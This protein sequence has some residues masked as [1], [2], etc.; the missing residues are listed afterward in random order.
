MNSA[1]KKVGDLRREGFE[2]VTRWVRRDDKTKLEH[3]NWT[4]YSGWP[5]AFVV[6][7]TV[8]YIGLTERILRSRMDDYRPIKGE[9]TSRMQQLITAELA[10][11]RDVFVFGRR[12]ADVAKLWEDEARLRRDF[13]P[14]WNRC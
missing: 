11:G 6:G 1:S 14:A 7:D 8:M 3:L 10:S 13:E 5:Y 2:Q 12:E 4:E 9:Q